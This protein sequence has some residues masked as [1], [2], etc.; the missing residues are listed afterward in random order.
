MRR[1]GG[2]LLML[3]ASPAQA[4]DEAVVQLDGMS[5]TGNREL[6]KSLYIV[7]WKA[8]LPGEFAGRPPDSL[9]DDPLA[10]LDRAVFLRELEYHDALRRRE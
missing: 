10:P 8:P 4:A 3:L 5:V 1:A 2:V 9:I 6:P 7:P